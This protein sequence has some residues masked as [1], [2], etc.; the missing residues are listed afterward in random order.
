MNRFRLCVDNE[1]LVRVEGRLSN[2]PALTED[3]KHPLI[4]PS[5]CALTRLE[6]LQYHV[7]SCHVGVQH[8]LLST[9]KKFWIV[10]GNAA[11]KR[12]LSQRGR[13]SLEKTKPVRQ[14]IADLPVERT[15]AG[16]KAFAV[17][18]LDYFGHVIMQRG[19]ALKKHGVCCSRSCLRDLFTW[20]LSPLSQLRTS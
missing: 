16:H 13:C 8:T 5:E 12:Y 7:D 14:L 18:G 11:G 9:R 1:S 3:M 20:E 2:S 10:N 17:C 4:L 6:V 19:E 15:T